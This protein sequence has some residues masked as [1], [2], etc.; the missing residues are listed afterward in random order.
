VISVHLKLLF[1]IN[2]GNRETEKEIQTERKRQRDRQTE[3]GIDR[4]TDRLREKERVGEKE[5]KHGE[6]CDSSEASKLIAG[7][8]IAAIGKVRQVRLQVQ[9]TTP[10]K[11]R[12]VRKQ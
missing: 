1:T 12:L 3:T 8:S 10:R 9:M 6:R 7:Y 11:L 4:D 5:R 2:L